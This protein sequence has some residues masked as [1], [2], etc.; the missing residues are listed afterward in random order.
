M[1]EGPKIHIFLALRANN[2]SEITTIL[3]KMVKFLVKREF[4]C[5]SCDISSHGDI[6]GWQNS[7]L[8]IWAPLANFLGPPPAVKW[9]EVDRTFE[10]E[11]PPPNPNPGDAP[12][13]IHFEAIIWQSSQ[14]VVFEVSLI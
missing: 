10:L 6:F 11:P 14:G 2:T 1:Q 9:E 4:F 5:A 8:T 12:G 13:P 3:L 7:Y